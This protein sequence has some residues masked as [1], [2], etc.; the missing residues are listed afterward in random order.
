VNTEYECGV[1]T[2]W[3]NVPEHVDS[4]LIKGTVS[5]EEFVAADV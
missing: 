4:W 3:M 2:A 1:E 5:Q